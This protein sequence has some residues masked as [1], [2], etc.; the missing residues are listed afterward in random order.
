MEQV[1]SP[2]VAS[3]LATM[4]ASGLVSLYV[5]P[6]V[7]LVLGIAPYFALTTALPM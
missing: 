1:A 4:V 5:P 2:D 6:V 7:F 3:A